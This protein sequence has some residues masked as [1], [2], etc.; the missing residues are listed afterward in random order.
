M[1]SSSLLSLLFIYLL[2]YHI[3]LQDDLHHN[4]ND[5]VRLLY[6]HQIMIMMMMMTLDDFEEGGD[7]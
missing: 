5:N 6:S 3:T 7:G 4:D 1:K 2:L